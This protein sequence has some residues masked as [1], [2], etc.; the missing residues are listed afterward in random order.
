MS[1]ENSSSGCNSTRIYLLILLGDSGNVSGR[2]SR[3]YCLATGSIWVF[4]R[5]TETRSPP[6][7]RF[8]RQR[9]PVKLVEESFWVVNR[10]KLLSRQSLRS[11]SS[12]PTHKV[13]SIGASSLII[14]RKEA[15][16]SSTSIMWGTRERFKN[17]SREREMAFFAYNLSFNFFL[18][19]LGELRPA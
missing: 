5:E 19:A 12:Q 17:S 2:D 15:C 18:S 4:I 6:H 11:L 9:V 13:T 3:G 8:G 14:V 7:F 10:R 16:I 1:A